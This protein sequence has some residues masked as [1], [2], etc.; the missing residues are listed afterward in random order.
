M[1]VLLL[2]ED[3]V[4]RLLHLDDLLEALVEGF[5]ALTSGQV[6]APARN[7]VSV[8]DGFLLTM[9]AHAPGHSIV[10]KLVSI[11]HGNHRFGLPGHQALICLL[12]PETGA[13]R[14]VMD[15]TFIT[16]LRTAAAAALSTRLLA[17]EQARTLA[18]VGAGV[19]GA[20]HLRM[21][22]RARDFT[23][24]RVAS[25]DVA[26]VQR[27]A[28]LDSRARAVDSVEQA[29]RGAD[30]VSLCT[31]AGHPVVRHAWLT[32]GAHVTSVGYMPPDG[33][34]AREILEQG[35]LFVE[36]RLA[37]AAPPVGCAELTGLDPERGT[38]LGEVLLGTRPGRQSP[39]ELTV[40]KSMGH[41]VEDMVAADL[42]FRRAAADGA[43]RL[44]TL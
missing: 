6:V 11:F 18:I 34:L 19:Q 23:E 29:V 7:E 38:E 43:G 2:S 33:E 10:V 20:A 3:D 14:A 41:A 37:F 24:I 44:V 32:P 8:P 39:V 21:L 28:A 22:P 31:T 17:R 26:D 40:Y 5:K 9:P 1:E 36:T 42:V 35:R 16:A 13:T 12:D 25:L 15:G 30:V 27:V 4:K